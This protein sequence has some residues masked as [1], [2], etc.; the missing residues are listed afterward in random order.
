MLDPSQTIDT[1]NVW[2]LVGFLM[3]YFAV[4]V[5]RSLE[6]LQTL[7]SKDHYCEDTKGMDYNLGGW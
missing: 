2:A 5:E 3:G 7:K 1:G 4:T 6:V